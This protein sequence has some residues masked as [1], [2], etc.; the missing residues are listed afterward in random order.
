VASSR[1]VHLCGQQHN[2]TYVLSLVMLPSA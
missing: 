2:C 1:T